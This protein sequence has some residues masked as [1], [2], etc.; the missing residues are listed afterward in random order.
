MGRVFFLGTSFLLVLALAT[1]APPTVTLPDSATVITGTKQ[2]VSGKSLDIYLSIPFAKPPI[3]DLRF[4]DPEPITNLPPQIDATQFPLSCYQEQFLSDEHVHQN[5]SEDC[6]YLNV[7]A[8]SQKSNMSVL[9]FIYGGSFKF[10]STDEF[11]NNPQYLAARTDMVIVT[12]NYRVGAFGFIDLKVDGSDGNLGLKDQILAFKWVK[13][14]IRAFGGNPDSVTISG[15]SAGSMAVGIHLSIEENSDL[16]HR[17]FL[18]SGTPNSG[19]F[20]LS[21][22]M[23]K[24]EIDAFFHILNCNASSPTALQ[25]LQSKSSQEILDAEYDALQSFISGLFLPSFNSKLFPYTS[26]EDF[27]KK[28]ILLN[29]DILIGTTK[30]EGSISF[31]LTNYEFEKD[32]ATKQ[33]AIDY[34]HRTFRKSDS[35]EFINISKVY[36]KDVPEHEYDPF[37]IAFKE[38]VG[39]YWFRCPT[40]YFS[41]IMAAKGNKVFFYYFAYQSEHKA[42]DENTRT[43]G[44]THNE[45]L[46]YTMGLPRRN[47]FNYTQ[48]EFEFANTLMDYVGNFSKYG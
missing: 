3:G 2:T 33:Y 47:A 25:C 5:M 11:M 12:M 43:H 6:L 18:Q 21:E 13:K 48:E 9:I 8:P 42:N 24:R 39:D 31:A 19:Y 4:K 17:A 15:T 36:L 35:S 20:H 40:F 14:N 37:G 44:A 32:N 38:A 27:N 41:N 28:D 23:I 1:A 16:F 22:N 30:D 46:P 29:K 34:F 10:G 26:I 45:D 7:W